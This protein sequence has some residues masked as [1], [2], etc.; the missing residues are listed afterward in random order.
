MN[1]LLTF[2][3]A[4][5]HTANEDAFITR[6][7]PGDDTVLI[8]ALADG[9]GGRPGGR[10]AAERACTVAVDTALSYSPKQLMRSKSW[11]KVLCEAD[12]AVHQDDEAGF[13][14]LV[15]LCIS[16][17]VVCG[18]S[19]GDSAAVLV[20]VYDQF[21]TLT[22]KQKKN[23]PVGTG[24]AQFVLFKE[25][26]IDPWLVILMSDGLW[27]YVGWARVTSLLRR[28]R[29]ETLLKELT[30]EARLVGRGTYRDD[31]TIIIVES[32]PAPNGAADNEGQG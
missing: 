16:D 10:E 18:G 23:P 7:H 26:L 4:G 29:G 12:K 1:N 19:S 21:R 24:Q 6:R 22:K 11:L 27:K 15:A 30:T 17:G 25:S 20:N 14:T 32:S 31:T 8:C 13:T 2:S 3:Q 28:E 9:Q 5:G